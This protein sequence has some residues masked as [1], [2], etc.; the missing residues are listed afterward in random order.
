MM[1]RPGFVAPVGTVTHVAPANNDYY[2]N[3]GQL[4]GFDQENN[5]QQR[6]ERLVTALPN[7]HR[8]VQY[9]SNEQ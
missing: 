4:K 3:Y 2:G 7:Q 1:T 8:N 9:D 5:M 6:R